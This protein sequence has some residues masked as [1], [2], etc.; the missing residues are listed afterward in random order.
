MNL[1][2]FFQQNPEVAIA[3]S[4][5]VDSSYLL[6]AATR[7]AKRDKAYYV[8]AEFQPQFE[9]DDAKRL[10]E[11]LGADMQIIH[12]SV[13]ADPQVKANPANRCYY[14][15]QGIFQTIRKAAADDGFTVLLDGTNAS[16]DAADRPGM[17]ALQELLVRSPLRECGLTKDEI[18]RLSKEAGLFT[19][20]KPAYACLAT[21]IPTGEEITPEKL[22]AVEKAESFLMTLG[23]TDFRVRTA[24]GHARIQLPGNQTWH[25][26]KN[27]DKVLAELKPLFKSVSLDL[28]ERS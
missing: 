19:W 23:F 17:K 18:R 24:G 26:L 16:D 13:L 7:Y 3:F 27:K 2:E 21:R 22:I 9:L 12:V 15:K 20:D 25:L 14:C 10:A 1:Q 6:Y 4:G 28:E 8:Q 5:G 11:E